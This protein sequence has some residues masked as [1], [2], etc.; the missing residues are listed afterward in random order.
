MFI[1]NGTVVMTTEVMSDDSVIGVVIGY[2]LDPVVHAIIIYLMIE[3][4]ND[5]YVGVIRWI[6][7]LKFC[8]CCNFLMRDTIEHQQSMGSKPEE[9]VMNRKQTVDTKT[10]EPPPSPMQGQ[11][12]DLTVTV[13]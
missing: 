7:K 11:P 12:R 13:D 10:K 4:N 9:P 5:T 1:I 3:R 8:C 6:Y 2:F